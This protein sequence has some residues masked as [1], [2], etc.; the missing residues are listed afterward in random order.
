MDNCKY[1]KG[2]YADALN[3]L[4]TEETL[5]LLENEKISFLRYTTA[6]P[7]CLFDAI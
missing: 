1:E 4:D 7:D 2:R 3:I 5:T 6:H